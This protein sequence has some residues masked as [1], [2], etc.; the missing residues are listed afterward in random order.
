[1]VPV[2]MWKR[3]IKVLPSILSEVSSLMKEQAENRGKLSILEKRLHNPYFLKRQVT[4]TGSLCHLASHRPHLSFELS[5][6]IITH[7]GENLPLYHK[8]LEE[9][10]TACDRVVPLKTRPLLSVTREL[11]L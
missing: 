6:P 7:L 4:C 3:I 9:T 11:A 5:A 2:E 1:M 10:H 8:L